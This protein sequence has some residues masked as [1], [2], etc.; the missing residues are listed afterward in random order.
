MKV[1]LIDGVEIDKA[2]VSD[3]GG[4]EIKC[5]W[6]SEATGT[7]DENG[8]GAES[9]LASRAYLGKRKMSRVATLFFG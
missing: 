9:L 3:T 6:A 1:T 8:S 5:G 7:D 2:D 4:S